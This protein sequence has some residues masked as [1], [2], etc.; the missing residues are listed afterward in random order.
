M[1]LYPAEGRYTVQGHYRLRNE[2]AQP[3]TTI[4]LGVDPE[5][6]KPQQPN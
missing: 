3:I 5:I 4:W 6:T 2:S 1:D